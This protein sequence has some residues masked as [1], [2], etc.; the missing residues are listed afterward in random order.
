MNKINFDVGISRTVAIMM[1]F[2]FVDDPYVLPHPAKV[3]FFVILFLLS[4]L[5]FG[6]GGTRK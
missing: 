1:W 5:A 6:Y 3:I 4:V 2:V